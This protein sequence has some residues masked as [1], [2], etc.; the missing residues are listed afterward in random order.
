MATSTLFAIHVYHVYRWSDFDGGGSWK[1]TE[2][3]NN[4]NG[5]CSNLKPQFWQTRNQHIYKFV[6]CMHFMSKISSFSHI[7]LVG[8]SPEYNRIQLSKNSNNLETFVSYISH[9]RKL[10]YIKSLHLAS[11]YIIVLISFIIY[12]SMQHTKENIRDTRVVIL[13]VRCA[14]HLQK[15]HQW[16]L[17]Q[18]S[19][20]GKIK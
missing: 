8:Q 11:V 7:S 1:A 2:M 10:L 12:T 20:T 17:N 15:T 6:Y 13:Y 9:L 18:K 4:P 3:T 19:K 5:R 16:Y 14:F